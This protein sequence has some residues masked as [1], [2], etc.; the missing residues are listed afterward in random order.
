VSRLQTLENQVQGALQQY[1][2]NQFELLVSQVATGNMHEAS[3]HRYYRGLLGPQVGLGGE[4]STMSDHYSRFAVRGHEAAIMRD[5]NREHAPVNLVNYICGLLNDP[6]DKTLN[7]AM[8]LDWFKDHFSAATHP[9]REDQIMDQQ[10]K[11][12][13]EAV[14][15]LLASMGV[16][17][18]KVKVANE[19]R[20]LLLTLEQGD[21]NEIRRVLSQYAAPLPA[22]LLEAAVQRGDPEIFKEVMLQHRNR[23]SLDA[24]LHVRDNQGFTLTEYAILEN[25][26]SWATILLED[27]HQPPYVLADQTERTSLFNKVC[28]SGNIEAYHFMRAQFHRYDPTGNLWNSNLTSYPTGLDQWDIVELLL[29]EKTV[30]ENPRLARGPLIYALSVGNRDLAQ[31]FLKLLTLDAICAAIDIDGVQNEHARWIRERLSDES[32]A[33]LGPDRVARFDTSQPARS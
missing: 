3:T 30:K 28:H 25:Q 26:F 1:R 9:L 19:K 8:V 23:N 16:I 5:F 15:L 4:M 7:K 29:L 20:V 24:A 12:R 27:G 32:M 6:K 21:L 10:G 13:P 31:R 2:T 18:P 22:G 11:W 14:G 17:K 33:H